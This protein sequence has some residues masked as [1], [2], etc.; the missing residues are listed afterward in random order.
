[1]YLYTISY[2]HDSFFLGPTIQNIRVFT[3]NTFIDKATPLNVFTLGPAI[4][5]VNK[6]T[7]SKFLD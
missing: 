7:D 2:P 5:A 4:W 6:F 3:G 1:M